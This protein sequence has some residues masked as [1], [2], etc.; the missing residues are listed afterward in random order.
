[1]T[2]STP[3]CTRSVARVVITVMTRAVPKAP[4]TCW[5]V[6]SV[7]LPC[8]YSRIGR[9]PR[10]RV[11]AGVNSAARLTMST[12]WM[13]R[14]SQY[15][16]VV[17]IC[18][19][20]NRLATISREPGITSGRPPK[21]SN[22]APTRG[23]STPIARPPGITSRPV[24]S[25][26]SPRTS[27]RYSGS[28]IIAPSIDRNAERQQDQREPVGAVAEHPQVEQRGADPDQPALAQHEHGDGDDAAHDDQRGRS[29][30]P[31][32]NSLRP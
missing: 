20:A 21:R 12:T 8:E 25:G 26:D 22:A 18:V 27:C 16:V 10:P 15:D 5:I 31:V 19:S 24:L 30:S 17:L 11:N 14:I 32:A 4:A 9:S 13:P 1:M 3:A 28:R 29:R 7:E 6:P 23:P 2:W